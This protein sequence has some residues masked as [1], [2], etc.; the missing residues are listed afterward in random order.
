[1]FLSYRNK[2][3]AA[4]C[5]DPAEVNRYIDTLNDIAGQKCFAFC[6]DS[7]HSHLIGRDIYSVIR[8]LGHRIECLHIHDN[9]GWDDQ[10]LAPYMGRL[11]WDRFVFAMREIGYRGALNFESHGVISAFDHEIVPAALKLTADTGKLFGRRITDDQ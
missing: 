6:Y 9:D 1:M 7:G 11:D 10:H 3:Y 8:Q 2:I 4:V 5:Q